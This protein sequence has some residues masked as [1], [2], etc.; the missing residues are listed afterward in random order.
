MARDEAA[1]LM[2]EM[3]EADILQLVARSCRVT[4][5]MGNRRYHEWVFDIDEGLIAG[6]AKFELSEAAQHQ[7]AYDASTAQPV[8]I[9]KNGVIQWNSGNYSAA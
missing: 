8:L 7:A 3:S 2:P 5:P 4:H 9:E 1:D 6:I